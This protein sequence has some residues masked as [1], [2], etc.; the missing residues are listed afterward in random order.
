MTE[1]AGHQQPYGRSLEKPVEQVLAD[2][3]PFPPFD[4]MVIDDLTEDE[5]DD[6][7]DAILNA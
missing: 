2:A 3:K 1:P 5:A 6:F 7:L 4:E